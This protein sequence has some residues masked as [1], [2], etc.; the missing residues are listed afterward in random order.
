MRAIL[1]ATSTNKPGMSDASGVFLPEA[2]RLRDLLVRC[3]WSVQL[4]EVPVSRLSDQQRRALVLQHVRKASHPIDLVAFFCHG[5]RRGIQLGFSVETSRELARTIVGTG[6]F[7]KSRLVK[8]AFFACSTGAGSGEY[9]VDQGG[10]G[11]EGGFADTLAEDLSGEGAYGAIV[12][13]HT[14]VGHATQ[15]PD[16]VACTALRFR[17]GRYGC[18]WIVAPDSPRRSRWNQL[19]HDR[20]SDYRLAYSMHRPGAIRQGLPAGRLGCPSAFPWGTALLAG[21]LALAGGVLVYRYG[22]A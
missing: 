21:A 22:S 17:Q 6:F 2:R 1:F 5:T 13:A 19:L 15:N 18:D 10:P 3:G 11:G 8:V 12:Y 14:T 7:S 4:I 16:A 9:P 20:S